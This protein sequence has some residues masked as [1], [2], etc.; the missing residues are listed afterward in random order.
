MRPSLATSSRL[1]SFTSMGSVNSP[2]H[3]FHHIQHPMTILTYGTF[4]DVRLHSSLLQLRFCKVA[5]LL[6]R[7]V[8]R[9]PYYHQ[10]AAKVQQRKKLEL[11]G[12]VLKFWPQTT[13]SAQ[14]VAAKVYVKHVC[15]RFR[16]VTANRTAPCAPHKCSNELRCICCFYLCMEKYSLRLSVSPLSRVYGNTKMA[17][18]LDFFSDCKDNTLKK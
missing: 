8:N 14:L 1:S 18:L 13:R 15:Q 16:F 12:Q 17:V 10:A 11:I 9:S 6:Q 4:A 2:F 5:S 7:K 3:T